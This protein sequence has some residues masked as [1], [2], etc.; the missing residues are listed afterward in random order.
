MVDF[1][2]VPNITNRCR[3]SNKTSQTCLISS[4]WMQSQSEQKVCVHYTL[5]DLFVCENVCHHWLPKICRLGLTFKQ[6]ACLDWKSRRKSGQKSS[7]VFQPFDALLIWTETNSFIIIT[8]IFSIL[9]QWPICQ[10]TKFSCKFQHGVTTYQK[11]K[12]KI[13]GQL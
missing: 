3:N 11:K 9:K 13:I 10:V 4:D 12:R 7:C 5:C 6:L 2:V 1:R 8:L